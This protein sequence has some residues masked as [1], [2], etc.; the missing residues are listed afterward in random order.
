MEIKTNLK[1]IG[2][3]FA[4]LVFPIECL[5]CGKSGSYLCDT[6]KDKLP[7]MEWQQCLV[8][9]KPS[10]FGKTHTECVTRNSV[11]GAL[12]ALPHKNKN[13]YEIIKTFKYDFVSSLSTPLASLIVQTIKDQGLENYFQDFII[14][15]V[16]L[17]NRRY[18]WRGFNQALLLSLALAKNLGTKVDEH[19]VIRKKYT[20]PQ[21]KLS[22]YE[23]KQNMENAFELVGDATNKKI[24]L[25]DDVITSGSTAN[26]LAKLLKQ[27]KALEVW[28]VSAAHG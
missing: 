15:P 8:C 21:V 12:S 10:P 23:R 22:A 19:L 6:C 13:V 3:F 28:V 27:A 24:I 25:V 1:K 5:V 4:D 7:K 2:G 17:H 20:Q 14:I 16:P 9:Q 11:D 26:E 18:N